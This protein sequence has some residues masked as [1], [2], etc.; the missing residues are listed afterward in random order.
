MLVCPYEGIYYKIK[1]FSYSERSVD[2][3]SIKTVL[4][5]VPARL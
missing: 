5:S 3:C 1:L 2:L 4:P